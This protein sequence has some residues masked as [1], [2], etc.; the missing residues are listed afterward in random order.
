MRDP[1]RINPTLEAIKKI[2]QQKPDMRLGQLLWMLNDGKDPFYMEDDVLVAKIE[3]QMGGDKPDLEA[4]YK[5]AKQ[6]FLEDGHNSEDS[7]SKVWDTPGEDEA[8]KDL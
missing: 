3:H 7:F 5:K 2:W 8:W 1:N 6:A 4:L